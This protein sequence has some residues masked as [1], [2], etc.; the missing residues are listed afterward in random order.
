MIFQILIVLIPL[1]RSKSI[2]YVKDIYLLNNNYLKDNFSITLSL[3]GM[4]KVNIPKNLII[5]NIFNII[6]ESESTKEQNK[7]ITFECGLF[8]LNSYSEINCLLKELTSSNFIG[9]FYLWI[10]NFKKSFTIKFNGKFLDFTLEI[11]EETFY[12]GMI[13]SFTENKSLYNLQ[14]NYR[15]S[16]VIIPIAMSLD[17]KYTYPTIVSITSILVNANSNIKYNFY[18]L[19]PSRFTIQNKKN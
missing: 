6:I 9:P 11:L 18:I 13:R 12:I 2:L 16:D 4:N 10:E 19:H 15:V 3:R 1:I 14:F 8:N 17:D 7:I 5:N